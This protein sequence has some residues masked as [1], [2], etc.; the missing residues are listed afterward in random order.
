MLN[1]KMRFGLWLDIFL[2]L[3]NLTFIPLRGKRG[4]AKKSNQK[5]KPQPLN[6][7]QKLTNQNQPPT[8]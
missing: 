1:D 3:T 2:F 5:F 7:N 4:Q 6:H 8:N